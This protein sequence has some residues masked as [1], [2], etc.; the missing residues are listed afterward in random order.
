APGP[1]PA[2]TPAPEMTARFDSGRSAPRIPLEVA[3]EGLAFVKGRIRDVDVWLLLDTASAS[4]VSKGVAQRLGLVPLGEEPDAA[5]ER[6]SVRTL[7]DVTIRLPGVELAQPSVSSY[8]LDRYQ[9]SLGH[10]VDGILGTG[11]FGSFV[12]ELDYTRALLTIWNANA[13]RLSK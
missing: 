7:R 4:V 9:T 8:D 5:G 12:V 3:G 6:P 11:F 1:K 13:H 10:R 2:T